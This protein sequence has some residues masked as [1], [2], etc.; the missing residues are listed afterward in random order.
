MPTWSMDSPEPPIPTRYFVV[1]SRVLIFKRMKA[2]T[3]T[4]LK[5]KDTV[6]QDTY[7][8]II[9]FWRII[10]WILNSIKS[11]KIESMLA[12]VYFMRR[13]KKILV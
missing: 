3:H 11:I 2:I 10:S 13:E 6:V 7:K 8:I 9:K 5:G 1:S 12:M 4:T